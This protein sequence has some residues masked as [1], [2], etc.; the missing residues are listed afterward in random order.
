[1]ANLYISCIL[2]TQLLLIHFAKTGAK[3]PAIIVFGDSTVDAGNNNVIPT[4][5]KS[6]F[7]PYGRDFFG[8]R[9]TGRFS[10]GR[11]LPDFISEAFGL[12]PIVPA[13]LDSMYSIS[14]F[15]TGVCFASAGTG[16]DNATSDVFN[17]I[18]LWKEVEYYKDYQSKLRA[19]LGHRKANY[20]LREALYLVSLGTNDFL[21]NYYVFPLRQSEFT[22]EQYQDFL[23]GLSGNF[24]REIYS[25][26]A[27]KISLTGLPPMGCLPLE[28][29]TN[30]FGNH[31][32]IEEYNKVAVN[33]NEK[34][35]GLVAKL[36]QDLPELKL[37][38]TESMYDIAYQIIKK[39]ASFG[40]DVA[41]VA[42]CST[43]T[44][45]VSCLC[46]KSNP[47]TCTDANK[48]VYWDAFHATERT[49]KI[50][51]D[52]MT[53]LLLKEFS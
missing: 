21:E 53:G 41:R 18:P 24:L 25:L 42:C 11:I 2:F 48:Y 12:K 6:N 17:V 38:F 33:F 26:G 5:L 49:N 30:I 3:V 36:N 13:Y 34:L 27:R 32:C 37:V 45:E 20:V 39:P 23:I 9:P 31:E 46:S 4:L 10:N 51:V 14:D 35:K 16:Y 43:G 50:I 52:N 7:Q 47:L 8:G 29:T 22:V 19:Y 15:T 28:R 44:F 1:M 40:F